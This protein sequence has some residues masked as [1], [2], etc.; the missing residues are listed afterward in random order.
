MSIFLYIL[1]ETSASENN[2][3]GVGL[4]AQAFFNG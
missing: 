2:Q 1:A 3:T 4:K